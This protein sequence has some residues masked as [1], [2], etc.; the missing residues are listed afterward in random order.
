[1]LEG[2]VVANLGTESITPDDLKFR[3]IPDKLARNEVVIMA[4]WQDDGK[5]FVYSNQKALSWR[6][7]GIVRDDLVQQ[8]QN[9]LDLEE[10]YPKG[11]ISIV[12]ESV[13]LDYLSNWQ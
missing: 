12:P 9:M 11:D 10:S 8:A 4:K 3:N 5:M 1:M 2:K 7:S 13:F 6:A